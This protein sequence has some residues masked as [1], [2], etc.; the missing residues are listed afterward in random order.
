M[1]AKTIL[2]PLYVTQPDSA[3]LPAME[4]C[5][6]AG[7]HLTVLLI[8]VAPTPPFVVDSMSFADVWVRQDAEERQK[9]QD[10][11]DQIQ[12]L[13]QNQ[14]V[15]FDVKVEYCPLEFVDAA[16]GLNARYCD[17]A[18]ILKG[19]NAPDGLREHAIS[20]VLFD[21]ARPA[22]L[23]GASGFPSPVQENV[24]IAWDGSVPAGRAIVAA[25]PVLQKAK[26][27]SV[28]CV[29]PE[30]SMTDI[31]EAPGWDLAQWLARHGVRITVSI[32]AGEG[33]SVAA[34]IERHA[35]EIGAGLIV[36]GGYGHSRFRQR[37]FGGTTSKLLGACSLP[38]LMAH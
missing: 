25:I 22:L 9:L 15:S 12:T 30:K 10:R 24:L 2:F 14:G 27:A 28:L 31:G 38:I 26:S 16:V 5:R 32:L 11:R 35:L 1:S 7:A 29:D 37:L 18:L 23:A 4:F 21:A 34:T 36:A 17:I 3:I 33:S 8:A 19:T 20:G 6:S 13:L